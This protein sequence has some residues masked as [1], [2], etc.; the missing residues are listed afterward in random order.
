MMGCVSVYHLHKFNA[1]SVQSNIKMYKSKCYDKRV[2]VLDQTKN[3][4]E[5]LE[6]TFRYI[7][8]NRSS[9]L[10]WRNSETMTELLKF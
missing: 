2:Y 6:G 3:I 7:F 10:Q 5:Q 8:R 1:N 9:D 4:R